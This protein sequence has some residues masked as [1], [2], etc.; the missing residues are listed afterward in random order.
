M[1]LWVVLSALVFFA[2]F[3]YLAYR[4]GKRKGFEQGYC[5]GRTDANLWWIKLEYEVDQARQKIWREHA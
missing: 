4:D 1:N 2:V 3:Q 5:R